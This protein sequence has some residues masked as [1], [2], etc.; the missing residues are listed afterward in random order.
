MGN[1]QNT[2]SHPWEIGPKKGWEKTLVCSLA[3]LGSLVTKFLLREAQKNAFLE[4]WELGNPEISH[5]VQWEIAK[6]RFPTSG[7]CVRKKGGK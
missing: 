4:K 2:F 5:S 7:K 3:S 1:R 6:T